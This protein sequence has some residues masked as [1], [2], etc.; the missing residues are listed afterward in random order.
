MPLPINEKCLACSKVSFRGE[1]T[2]PDCW[3]GHA[4][5]KKRSYYRKLDKYRAINRR[6]HHYIKYAHGNCA[7]CSSNEQ[8][9]AHHINAQTN[10]GEHTKLNIMTLCNKCHSI[11]TKYYQAIRGLKQ[12]EE[13]P[14]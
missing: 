7:I 5:E 8:L 12:I 11:V 3:A 10:G 1:V 4:C 14:K 6:N 2:R 13:L 9:E